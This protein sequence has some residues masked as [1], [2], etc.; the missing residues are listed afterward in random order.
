MLTGVVQAALTKLPG[1][2]SVSLTGNLLQGP[3]PEFMDT[4][5]DDAEAAAVNGSF[6]RLDR[7]PCDPRVDALVSIAGAFGHPSRESPSLQ[8]CQQRRTMWHSQVPRGN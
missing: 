6:C 5:Q 7:G 8:R 4:V 3:L 1:L 2:V